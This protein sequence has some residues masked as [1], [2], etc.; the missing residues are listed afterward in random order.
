M[1]PL[2]LFGCTGYYFMSKKLNDDLK[3]IS[4][5]AF[6]GETSFNPGPNKQAQK[7]IFSRKLNKTYN[8]V[9]AITGA[10]R[11]TSKENIYQELGLESLEK[12]TMV[13]KRLLASNLLHTFSILSC[14]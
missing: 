2:S 10:I 1:I 11:G 5:Y 12:K 14:V 8:S 7:V 6:Q 13:S 9:L 3:K 4:K